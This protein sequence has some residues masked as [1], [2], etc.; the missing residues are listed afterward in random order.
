LVCSGGGYAGTLISLK[1]KIKNEEYGQVD[2]EQYP[3]EIF[4]YG[5]TVKVGKQ[6]E[7]FFYGAQLMY[8]LSDLSPSLDTNNTLWSVGLAV[9][10]FPF[11]L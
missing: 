4:D 9:S 1:Q 8:G 3:A 7:N 11:E 6:Q 10:Y 2:L 5:I